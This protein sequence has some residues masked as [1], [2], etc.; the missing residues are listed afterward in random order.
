MSCFKLPKGLIKEIEVLIRKFWWGYR[1]EHK[2]IHWVSWENLC[3]PKCEG[4]MGFREL[5]KFNDALLAKQIWRLKNHENSLFH[6]VFKAKFFLDC[7]VLEVT[8]HLKRSYAWKSILQSKH[9]IELGSIW[10]VG[11][12]KSV[13]IQGDKWL[14]NPHCRSTVSPIFSLSLDSTVSSLIDEE[15]QTGKSNLI[16]QEFMPHEANTI[17]RLPLSLIQAPDSQVWFPS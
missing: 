10:R 16:R 5:S 17:V 1:G 13:K 15:S 4:G 3:L 7:S 6:K 12:G 14:P 2:R 9:I 8:S 11:D